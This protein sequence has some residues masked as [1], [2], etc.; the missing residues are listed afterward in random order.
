MKLVTAFVLGF[1]A[2]CAHAT[3]PP[4]AIGEWWTPGFR[5]RV[6]VTPCGAAL[7]GRVVWSWDPRGVT[8]GQEVLS[9]FAPDARGGW[10][11]GRAFNPDDGHTYAASLRLLDAD[12]LLVEGCLLFLCREQVWLRVG[13]TA[14]TPHL[15]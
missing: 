15:R 2:G 7:C 11:G 5:G 3:E 10:S 9:A 14:V 1:L 4:T 6:A 12:H 8:L 13:A